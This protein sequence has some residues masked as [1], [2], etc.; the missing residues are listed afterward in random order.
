MY[1]QKNNTPKNKPISESTTTIKM[2]SSEYNIVTPQ[3][4]SKLVERLKRLENDVQNQS[5]K[6][7][8]LEYD[9][10]NLKRSQNR[11]NDNDGPKFY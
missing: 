11:N 3:E 7:R 5:N 6:I 2:G 1:N 9:I 10:R 8:R 4:F